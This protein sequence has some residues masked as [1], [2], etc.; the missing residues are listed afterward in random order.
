VSHVKRETPTPMERESHAKRGAKKLGVAP[1]LGSTIPSLSSTHFW[2]LWWAVGVPSQGFSLWFH[3]HSW[4]SLS[5]MLSRGIPFLHLV[6]CKRLGSF[7]PYEEGCYFQISSSQLHDAHCHFNGLWPHLVNL[8]DWMLRSWLPVLK[9][10]VFIHPCAQG[11]FIVEFDLQEDKD[12]IFSSALG[13]GVVL[14][15]V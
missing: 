12:L 3:C 8:H 15:Y 13:S 11:F 5:M 7:H 14:V 6:W 10:D 4:Q 1:S 2:I 9:G